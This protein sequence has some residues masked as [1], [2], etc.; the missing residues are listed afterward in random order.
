MNKLFL[1]SIGMLL[2]CT[3]NQINQSNDSQKRESRQ[4]VIS[5]NSFLI[6]SSSTFFCGSWSATIRDSM[7]FVV[8]IVKQTD[9][10]TLTYSNILFEGDILNAQTDSSDYASIISSTNVKDGKIE[11]QLKNYYD[12][13]QFKLMLTLNRNKNELIW[14]IFNFRRIPKYLPIKVTLNKTG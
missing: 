1:F 14:E 12:D 11:C 3:N 6:D 8:T 4:K 5:A 2:S 13:N 9:V 7:S 10:L